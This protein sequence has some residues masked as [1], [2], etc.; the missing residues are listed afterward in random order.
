MH[1][2]AGFWDW[3]CREAKAT[4]AWRPA[5]DWVAIEQA[6]ASRKLLD[7]GKQPA[8]AV[9]IKDAKEQEKPKI[10]A[11]KEVKDVKESSKEIKE[12]EKDKEKDEILF[13]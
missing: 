12:K 3:I 13:E 11:V 9:P 1:R 10:A 2:F 4:P 6:K 8:P 7:D 5:A